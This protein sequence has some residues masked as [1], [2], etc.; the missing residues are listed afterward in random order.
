MS[1]GST[2]PSINQDVREERVKASIAHQWYVKAVEKINE[3]RDQINNKKRKW[4]SDSI[5][6]GIHGQSEPRV[7]IENVPAPFSEQDWMNE[8][9]PD[10]SD[11]EDLQNIQQGRG[12][13]VQE[14]SLSPKGCN[15]A[16]FLKEQ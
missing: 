16:S 5:I 2:I 13:Q 15:Q 9:N 14:G 8:E 7:R 4:E 1:G 12:E 10:M 6:R 11:V 3:L